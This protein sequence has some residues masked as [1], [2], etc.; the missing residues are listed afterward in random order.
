MPKR[1]PRP[2]CT[3][4][5]LAILRRWSSGEAAD[6]RLTARAEI[7]L[8][9]LEGVQ[10]MQI[11]EL[12][13]INRKTA[14]KWRMRFIEKGLDGLF[15]DPR[16]G[17][18]ATYRQTETKKALRELLL[19]PPPPGAEFWDARAIA[20]TMGMPRNRV[21][22]LL[23]EEGI[24][25]ERRRRHR[26]EMD[27]MLSFLVSDVTGV[28]IEDSELALVLSVHGP[29]GVRP[30]AKVEPGPFPG[31]PLGRKTPP[32]RRRTLLEVLETFHVFRG[33][34][35]PAPKGYDRFLA[36]LE[37]VIR[38]SPVGQQHHV[39]VEGHTV[40]DARIAWL[41][42]RPNVTLHVAAELVPDPGTWLGAVE[43]A[44]KVIRSKGFKATAFKSG[45]EMSR[46]LAMFLDSDGPQRSP[47]VWVWR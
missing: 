29:H 22:T 13:D 33:R 32:A 1:C 11:A 41:A 36:F 45:A 37:R 24:R 38:R 26:S 28:Y 43:A 23:R 17:K 39:L 35:L 47:L 27:P 6:A 19:K 18:P 21:W 40:T 20:E 8:K 9:C 34:A 5:E 14:C 42:T 16:P 10:D 4:K 7:V 3:E 31:R 46:A 44:S 12:F 30:T 25:L 15:D 2:S